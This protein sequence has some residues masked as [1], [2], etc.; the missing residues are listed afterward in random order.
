MPSQSLEHGS[1]GLLTEEA[2]LNQIRNI[3][4][5]LAQGDI[6]LATQFL[7]DLIGMAGQRTIQFERHGGDIII[8]L[9]DPLPASATATA[10]TTPGSG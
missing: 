8:R 5:E 3:L 2:G 6:T 9:K 7:R 10:K 1:N 4:L